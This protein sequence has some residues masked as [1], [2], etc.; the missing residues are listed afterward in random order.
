MWVALRAQFLIYDFH[1]LFL[2]SGSNPPAGRTVGA[3]DFTSRLAS[4]TPSEGYV[5]RFFND[6]TEKLTAALLSRIDFFVGFEAGRTSGANHFHALLAADELRDQ[7]DKETELLRRYR[8][9]GKSLQDYLR[10]ED[11]LLWGYLYRTA[12]RSLVLPF[13]SNRGAGWYIAASYVGKNQQG[14]DVSIGN[15]ALIRRRPKKAVA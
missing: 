5:Q 7:L 14:W 6:W 15:R 13:D 3:R 4:H 2:C 12:G 9:K 11:L 8:E 1:D 10:N